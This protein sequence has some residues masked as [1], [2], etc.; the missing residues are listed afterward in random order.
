MAAPDLVNLFL[1]PVGL[2]LLGFVEPC[3]TGTNLLFIKHVEGEGRD[4]T[5]A[6]AGVFTLTRALFIGTL[7]A[8]AALAGSVFLGIQKGAW[9]ILGALYMALGALYLFGRAAALMR[10]FGPG[11]ARLYG[12]RGS[13]GLGV[14]FGLNIPACAAPLIFALLGTTAV[15]AGAD[16]ARGFFT[17]ALFGLALSLPLV[18]ALSWQPA[19]RALDRLAGL[20]SRLPAWTGIVF[21]GLGLWSVY[22]GLFV[23]LEDWA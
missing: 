16:V 7:G 5:M 6:R 9:M 14:L 23:S 19:R 1:V 2:G 10:G 20:S 21:I 15:G 12:V 17:L 8:G 13:I 4:A 22:F 3:S 11:L 18:L